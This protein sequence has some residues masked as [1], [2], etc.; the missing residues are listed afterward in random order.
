MIFKNHL[1]LKSLIVLGFVIAIVPLFTAVFFAAHGMRETTV[2]SKNLNSEVFDQTKTIRMVLQKASDVERKARLFVLLSDPAVRQPYERQSYETA[3]TS[4]KQSLADLL[5]L[6]VDNKIALLANELSEKENLIYQQIIALDDENYLKSPIDEAFQGLRESSYSLSRE[7]ENHVDREFDHLSHQSESLQQELFLKASGL[8]VISILCVVVLLAMTSRSLRQLDASI[9]R[10]V[11]GTLVEPI[12]LSGPSDL[13]YLGSRL[14]WL[15]THILELERS[16]RQFMLNFAREIDEPLDDIRTGAEM[17]SMGLDDEQQ[18]TVR[19]ICSNL[20]KME[21]IRK[22][23][24]RFGN[25]GMESD[26]AHR[27]LIDLADL[28]QIVVQELQPKFH[29]KSVSI[30]SYML[31]VQ[32]YGFPGQMKTVLEQL[33]SN[34]VK[35]SPTHGEIVILLSKTDTDLELIIEDEGPGVPVEQREKIFE[36]FFRGNTPTAQSNFADS[37]GLGL[38]MVRQYVANHFGNVEFIEPRQAH[39]GASVRVQI[40]LNPH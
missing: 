39:H 21:S 12:A 10:L 2:L 29:N 33:L 6:H 37:C 30:K 9:R 40:P 17:L 35:F 5:K 8:L 25:L 14:E 22:E 28:L 19:V 15:R 34:A 23:F 11:S 3:R 20:E 32:I 27:E 1:S 24:L 4:F 18:H 26:R 7:F 13:Q 36:P 38:A 31:P 16:K